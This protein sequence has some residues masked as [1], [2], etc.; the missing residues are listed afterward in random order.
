MYEGLLCDVFYILRLISKE[1]MTVYIEHGLR[2]GT[3]MM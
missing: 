1:F 3:G 2:T